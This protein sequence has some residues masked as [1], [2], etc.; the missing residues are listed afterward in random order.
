M[1]PPG[2]TSAAMST[3]DVTFADNKI[4]R[5]KAFHV[6]ADKVDHTD[7]FMADRHRHRN[8]FLGPG[9]PIIYVDVGAADVYL[10]EA[11]ETINYDYFRNQEIH[12]I[13]TVV[14]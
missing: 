13:Y 4:A 1:T 2:K 10:Q 11:N 9:V 7:K 8:R 5:H 12:D 14:V 3:S 6:I